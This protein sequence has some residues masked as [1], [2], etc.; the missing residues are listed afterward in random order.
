MLLVGATLS[1]G[2]YAAHASTNCANG[3]QITPIVTGDTLQ[4][5]DSKNA[6]LISPAHQTTS[7]VKSTSY[8]SCNPGKGLGNN[9]RWRSRRSHGRATY[10]VFPYGQ[11]TWW[12][13]QRYFQLHGVFVPWRTMA[14]AWQWKYRAYQFHW[15]VSTRPTVGSIMVLQPWTEGAYGFGHVAVVER[16]LRNGHVIASSMNWGARP[17]RVTYWRF[18]P[19]RGV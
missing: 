19:G 6:P 5:I 2:T 17:W 18:A 3:N 11:C 1:F 4:G 13:N 16:V 14:N 12:A 15:R 9:S 7:T 10:N 8:N